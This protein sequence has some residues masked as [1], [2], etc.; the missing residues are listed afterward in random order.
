M[1]ILV[2][3]NSK[4]FKDPINTIIVSQLDEM[5]AGREICEISHLFFRE[6]NDIEA[7]CGFHLRSNSQT[8]YTIVMCTCVAVRRSNTV[9]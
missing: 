8:L 2:R 4:I 1:N 6:N 5:E 7:E 3:N 9:D